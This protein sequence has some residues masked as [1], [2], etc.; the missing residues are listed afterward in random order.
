MLC[1]DWVPLRLRIH[2]RSSKERV[3]T[4]ATQFHPINIFQ[5]IFSLG[6]IHSVCKV[7]RQFVIYPSENFKLFAHQS[8]LCNTAKST[9]VCKKKNMFMF[10]VVKKSIH[11]LKA[12]LKSIWWLGALP[13]LVNCLDDLNDL[14]DYMSIFIFEN[15]KHAQSNEAMNSPVLILSIHRDYYWLH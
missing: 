2:A 11:P 12:R 13:G 8:Y 5:N 14:N 9:K 7:A 4:S 6:C 10:C 1:S 3:D 15:T